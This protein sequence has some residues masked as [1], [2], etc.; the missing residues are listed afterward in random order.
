VRVNPVRLLD[1]YHRRRDIGVLAQLDDEPK[2]ETI[3]RTAKERQ[4]NVLSRTGRE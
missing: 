1:P 4:E 2:R 3:V